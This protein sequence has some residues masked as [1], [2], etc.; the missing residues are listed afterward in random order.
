MSASRKTLIISIGSGVILGVIAIALWHSLSEPKLPALTAEL[1][2]Q[3]RARWAQAEVASYELSVEV[4][5][6]TKSTHV[7]Q[8]VNGETRTM[9][10]NGNPVSNSAARYWTVPGMFDFLEL[11]LKNIS[12]KHS[13]FGKAQVY[14]D[15][16]FDSELGFPKRFLRQVFGRT[17]T[18]EWTVSRFQKN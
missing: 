11:E 4:Q 3:A 16:E 15:A 18:V 6:N 8:V 17:E 5:G 14:L 10:T 13:P 1:L 12:G 9:Q 2:A 7:I